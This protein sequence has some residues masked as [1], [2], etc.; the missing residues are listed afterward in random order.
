MKTIKTLN[1]IALCIPIFISL[2]AIFERGLLALALLSTMVTGLIQIILAFKYWQENTKNIFINIY[3]FIVALFFFFLW[4]STESWI[5]C[6]PPALCLYLS[7]LIYT[8][9]T[10]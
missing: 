8:H 5:W 1:T 2:F 6:L 4:F 7:L 10:K 3:F 9:E